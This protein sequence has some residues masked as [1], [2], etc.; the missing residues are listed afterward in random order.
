[1]TPHQLHT[2]E[3]TLPSLTFQSTPHSG[4]CDLWLGGGGGGGGG[5]LEKEVI[6]IILVFCF[7]LLNCLFVH[8]EKVLV[9]SSQ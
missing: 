2:E 4:Q 9:S 5:E 3:V 1:M 8:F 7:S 6:F